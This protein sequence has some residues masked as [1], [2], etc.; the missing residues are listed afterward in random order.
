MRIFLD[1]AT[2]KKINAQYSKTKIALFFTSNKF[3]AFSYTII[4][5]ILFI[6]KNVNLSVTGNNKIVIV[7]ISISPN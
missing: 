5:L 4:E 6:I 3:Y 2:I 7:I 1:I